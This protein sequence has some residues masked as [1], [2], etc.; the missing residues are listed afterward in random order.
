MESKSK[1]LEL[2]RK[3]GQANEERHNLAFGEL[4]TSQSEIDETIGDMD[5][6]REETRQNRGD[7]ITADER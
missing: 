4:A 5:T 2:L 3:I 1:R 7:A 6:F